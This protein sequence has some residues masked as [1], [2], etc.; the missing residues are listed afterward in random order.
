MNT[1]YTFDADLFSDLYKDAYG[2]RPRHH[3][4]YDDSTTDAERQEFWDNTLVALDEAIA[5]EE[6]QKR[7]S[8]HRFMHLLNVTIDSGAG[9][10]ETALR[11]LTQEETFYSKQDVEH[12][13]WGKGLLFTEYGRELVEKLDG[14]VEYKEFD[15][16]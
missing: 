14:I 12:W 5:E 8:F 3:R 9:D 2:M 10:E 7:D 11:W 15:W 4:F 13:V 1:A 16:F 6:K